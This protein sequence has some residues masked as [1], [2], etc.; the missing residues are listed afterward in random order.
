MEK[1]FLIANVYSIRTRGF[2]WKEIKKLKSFYIFL[3]CGIFFI[4]SF[5]YAMTLDAKTWEYFL[6]ITITFTLEI[7]FLASGTKYFEK[8]STRIN[9]KLSTHLKTDIKNIDSAKK[10]LL[11]RKFPEYDGDYT[12]LIKHI[13]DSIATYEETK[14]K[15][16]LKTINIEKTFIDPDGKA[17][18]YTLLI[19]LFTL[20]ST[21][22]L[23]FTEESN[24]LFERIEFFLSFNGMLVLL[25]GAMG[26]LALISTFS[27]F[28]YSIPVIIQRVQGASKKPTKSIIKKEHLYNLRCLQYD[29]LRYSQLPKPK[30]NKD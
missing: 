20:I 8:T 18:F 11:K 27:F 16:G 6:F 12:N 24:D 29:L 14:K 25:T 1:L 17:R 23:K 7:G 15:L 30:S 22:S 10:L 28:A 13:K 5:I 19:A 3:I 9:E 4:P 21:Y 26:L 2:P